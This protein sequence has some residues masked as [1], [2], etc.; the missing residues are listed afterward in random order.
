MKIHGFQ[1]LVFLF[2]LNP[3][4]AQQQD[5]VPATDKSLIQSAPTDTTRIEI[6]TTQETVSSI[7]IGD[8][9]SE[10]WK[11]GKSK[12]PPKPKNMWELGLGAGHYMVTGD[13]D[14]RYPGWGVNIHVRKAIYYAFSLRFDAFYGRAYGMEPQP[15]TIALDNEP[16]IFGGY[17]TAA[18]GNA[19]FPAYRTQYYYAAL[20]G[21][22]NI[23]NILFHKDRNK[24]NWNLILGIG[25]DHHL[26]ELDLQDENGK[27]YENLISIT[28]YT[29][30]K[31][32]SSDGRSKIK[33]ELKNHYD[34]KY[35]TE[36]YKKKG[37]FRINDDINIHPLLIVGAG[38][39]RKLN[40]RFNLSLEHQMHI[41]DNDYLDGVIWRSNVDQTSNN[42]LQHYTNLRLAINLGS[43]KKKKE[44]LYWLN[45]LD[46]AF[47]DIADLKKRPI[48]DP[49]DNDNDGVIDILDDELDT[50][51]NAAV[52]T[53]GKALDSD[54]DGIADYLDPEPYSPPGFPRDSNGV[55][56]VPKG[57][58]EEDVNRLIDKRLGVPPGMF[59]SL[60]GK[61][62]LSQIEWFLPMIHFK[63]DEYCVDIK[64]APQLAAVAEVLQQHPGLKLTVHGH[65]DIRHTNA[66]NKMLS[67]NRANEAIGYLVEKYG[68]S[69]NR[70]ILIYGGEEHP[71]GGYSLNHP[72]NR[73][74]EFRV[75]S[76]DEVEMPK[77]DGPNAGACHKKWKR[78][79]A[80]PAAGGEKDQQK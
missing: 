23:G 61:G 62:L 36:A 45:P 9:A 64:Y 29:D 47:S 17:G 31:F 58:G 77:P 19:W 26:T 37:V 15:Y 46:A 5:T 53:H 18:G 65:T 80:A 73:R 49:T 34:G 27:P 21:I 20:E 44:P 69:R 76:A 2:W 51:A 63:L 54:D 60:G 68:V 8:P 78:K 13:V 79:A 22:L 32:N 40:D 12:Y 52:D 33:K 75:N 14:T 57:I 48:F 67:Y 35:E 11:S 1:L 41:T 70:L 4:F 72:I 42:D 6:T 71:L 16:T 66:Y 56:M 28:G 30:D 3:S 39:S 43:F 38:I 50:P 25:A 74:V 10:D 24:W 55:A 7:Q 59:D